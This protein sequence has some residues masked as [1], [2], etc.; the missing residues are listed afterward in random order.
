MEKIP[1]TIAW[2]KKFEYLGV[3]LTNDVND[4]YKEIINYWR[5]RSRKTT[6]DGK[7]SHAYGLVE[8]T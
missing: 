3:N 2:K 7:I 6:K 4:L 1:F 5:Q 8:S